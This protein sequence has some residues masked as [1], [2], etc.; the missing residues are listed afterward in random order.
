MHGVGKFRY[1]LAVGVCRVG[2]GLQAV[3]LELVT[4]DSWRAVCDFKQ[5]E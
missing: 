1:P 3:G 4:L 2:E 5:L